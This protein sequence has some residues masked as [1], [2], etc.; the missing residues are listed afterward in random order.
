MRQR[1]APETFAISEEDLERIKNGFYSDTYF[2]RT[3]EILAKDGRHPKVLMQIFQRQHAVLCGIDE[4]LHIIRRCAHHPENLVIH[5]LHDGDEVEPWETVM[6]IEGDLCDF[7]H[8][9]TVYLGI[10]SRQT[11]IATNVRQNVKA[12]NGKPVLFFPARFDH[13][14]VQAGDGYAARIG[15]VFGVSTPANALYWGGAAQ[16]TI[17]H[18][19]IATYG[20][21]T[22]A[23][24]AAFHRHV[25]TEVN[26]VA[27]V[28][29]TNDC[30]NTSL[31]VA[32]ELGSSLWAVRLD[33]ADN[34]VDVSVLPHM[35]NF[36]PTGVCPRLVRNVREAL[37]AEG[38]HHVKI[39]VS[40]GFNA[41][42]I[43]AFEKENVPVDIYAVGGSLFHNS[44]NFTADIVSVDGVPCAKV[45]RS[46]RPNHRLSPVI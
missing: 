3:R 20:G 26:R 24:T 34:L 7:S 33:T 35:G 16:G 8:L 40:G 23:A 10:L 30:V 11:K 13:Y 6:T 12:A 14:A 43:T 44:V 38:F 41:E 1:L 9:E 31:A 19:L 5:A 27:L 21:D 25:P 28:D 42:R 45:G 18:A 39:M 29:F 2:L 46:C 17:P 4:A 36:R 37:D 32:R 22:L 15:G